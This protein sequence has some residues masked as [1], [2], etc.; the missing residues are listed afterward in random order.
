MATSGED[1]VEL[2]RL[3]AEAVQALTVLDAA[4]IEALAEFLEED[5]GGVRL[6]SSS[7]EWA[8]ARSRQWI[9]GQ[10]LRGTADRLAMLR[11]VSG[12]TAGPGSYFPPREAV[13]RA[14]PRT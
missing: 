1:R 7:P 8:R 9:L 14:P 2:E 4:A 10:L 5:S 11:R 6:P 3:L 12:Q 13:L